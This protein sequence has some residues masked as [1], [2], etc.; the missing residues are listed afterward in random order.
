MRSR[1]LRLLLP[2]LLGC[3]TS[4]AQPRPPGARS[5]PTPAIAAR[6]YDGELQG[7][8]QDYGWAPRLPKKGRAEHLDLSNYGGWILAN[9]AL[10]GP[11]GGLVLR[12][13][14][15]AA[16]GDFLQVR[17][18]SERADVF[19]RVNPGPTHRKDLA[20]GWTEVYLSMSQL[21]PSFVAFDRVVLRAYRPL[22][23]GAA[24]EIDGIA[25]T[26]PDTALLAQMK[27]AAAAPGRPAEFE[28]DCGAATHAISPLIYGIAFSPMH[29]FESDQQ[30]K[31]G[32]SARRWGGNPTSRYNWELGNA[33]NTAVD[34]FWRNVN[35]TGKEDFTFDTFLDI[36]LERKVQTALTV[37]ILG[38]V[39]KDTSS[40]SFPVAEFGPQEQVDPDVP[41]AGNGLSRA[42]K[43]LGPAAPGRTSIAAPP[44]FIERWVR[45]VREKDRRRGRSIS[46][47]IL[48]NEPMLWNDTHRDVHPEPTTYDELLRRTIDYGGAVRRADPEAII[49]GPAEWGWTGYLFSA[50]DAK[51]GF[52]LKPDRRAH[53]DQPLVAW[54]LK[55]L[56]Q[57]QRKTGVRV[58]D[59]LDLHFYPQAKNLG[60][61]ADGA[62]D[63]ETAALRIRSTRALWDRTYKD[64][65]WINEPVQLIPRMRQWVTENYPGLKLSIGEYNFGAERHP[66][67][68]LAL[69]EALGRFGQEDLYSAFYWTVPPEGTP[70]FW[71]FR[72]YRNFDGQ[73]GRFLDWSL[74]ASAPRDSSVFASR[75]AE[76][77][78]LTLVALNFSPTETLDA[79]AL[80]KGCG[81]VEAQR[82]F[83]Y[84]GDPKGFTA[85]ADATVRKFRLPP[86][87][88]AVIEAT[89]VNTSKGSRPQLPDPKK[90]P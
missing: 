38:W 73:G 88:M 15:P 19:P 33:W 57:H 44:E 32:A 24:V 8:W 82:V 61:G 62:T 49:A 39:A 3:T 13:R 64:E 9:R 77:S 89:L 41:N 76:G 27:S 86:W 63:A 60:V 23:A 47:Y 29:E 74:P 10:E 4:T 48:D 31:V 72:A 54:Y 30:W 46:M 65:S 43:P 50:L 28:V 26:P 7:E 45:Q 78:K 67:G 52:T 58:L 51:R 75:N 70:A 2:L 11:F 85:Q 14:A 71:A 87:S 90:A 5:A 53:D 16:Y 55:Q 83:T 37:P 12:F 20:E 84:S 40:Y 34:Y 56:A 17:V 36:N 1:T 79:S 21:N 80:L 35:Y 25:L 6:I 69:A 68:G 18:D 59:V 66:S 42:G 22:P 81:A